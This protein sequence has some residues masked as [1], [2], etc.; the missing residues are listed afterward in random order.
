MTHHARSARLHGHS[1][2][3]LVALLLT[4]TALVAGTAGRAAAAGAGSMYVTSSGGFDGIGTDDVVLVLDGSTGATTTTIPVGDEPLNLAASPD[5]ALVYVPNH[6]SRTV[7]VIDTATAS[8]VRTV[9][10]GGE[11][12][13]VAASPDG[14]RI[15]VVHGANVD[16][17]QAIDT[18]SLEVVATRAVDGVVEG[19]AVS[20]DSSR[21]YVSTPPTVTVLDTGTLLPLG[22]VHI[23]GLAGRVVLSADG[24]RAYVPNLAGLDHGDA[25]QI[26]DTATLTLVANIPLP[27][28]A[29]PTGVAVAPNGTYALV[30]DAGRDLVLVLDT[31][32]ATITRS[33]PVGDA[34]GGIAFN[35]DGTRVFVTNYNG[36]SA[37]VLDG[38][39]LDVVAVVGAGSYPFGVVAAGSRAVADRP[40]SAAADAYSTDEDVAVVVPAPGVL[41]NDADAD[42][43]ALTA[44]LASLPAHGSVALG[45][46]GSFT[47]MPA[48]GYAGDDTFT[49]VARAAGVDSSPATVTIAVGAVNDAPAAADDA[50]G[51][52]EDV[53]LVV[54]APGVLDNDLDPDGDELHA[55]LADGPEHG[56][57][58]LDGD[59]GFTYVPEG[60]YAGLDGFAYRAVD[61][62]GATSSVATVRIAVA[63]L[64]DPAFARDDAYGTDEDAPLAVGPPGVLGND[65]DPDGD[66]LEAVLVTTT[67][68]GALA[69]AADGS[70]TYD[71]D[72]DFYG[73][74]AF[75]YRAWDGTTAPSEPATVTITI[76]P[77]NDPPSCDA[78]RGD[79]TR[80]WPPDHTLRTVALAGASDVDGDRTTLSVT[81][82]VQ[83]EPVDGTGD[84]DT[85]PDAVVSPGSSSVEV[86]AERA[87]TGDGRVYDVAYTVSDEAGGTCSGTVVV[88]VPH[89]QSGAG[90][91]RS[92]LAVDSTGS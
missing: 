77:V 3:L 52:E 36:D 39:S 16:V 74:D 30:T 31:A 46:D 79:A 6:R 86:R 60:D 58:E 55:V 4:S 37:S 22:S 8:V 32:T 34:P 45:E 7:S 41:G 75:T 11:P 53:A 23:G 25:I 47:Y 65:A 40:P 62:S 17:V 44:H 57:L 5:G 33:I 48:S 85:A 88:T 63:G 43:D 64:G 90:A 59:G 19:A 76:A 50:Y 66:E 38:S 84:G 21:L 42:G 56:S 72:A 73:T 82:V 26:I 10:V 35:G 81:A 70:F 78:V 87:G 83:D 67:A 51:T 24:S 89:R 29:T 61:P 18:A 54:A 9:P 49:Y 2:R 27:Y 15:Y 13:S 14:F 12:F 92:P 1:A 20:P 80:L 91:F 69:L 71:P 68:H 28:D